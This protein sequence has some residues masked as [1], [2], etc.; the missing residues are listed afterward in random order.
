M[1]PTGPEISGTGI[2]PEDVLLVGFGLFLIVDLLVHSRMRILG[3]RFFVALAGVWLCSTLATVLGVLFGSAVLLSLNP[4]ESGLLTILKEAELLV[5]FLIVVRYV[6]SR[7]M[8]RALVGTLCL[9]GTLFAV[10]VILEPVLF[11]RGE[12]IPRQQFHLMGDTFAFVASLSAGRLFF[13]SSSRRSQ[14]LY[15]G[16]LGIASV[17]VL[18]SGSAGAMVGAMVGMAMLLFVSLTNS[19]V[20]V[21]RWMFALGGAVGTAAIA[22][23]LILVPD[24]RAIATD[25]FADL[26]GVLT[27]N[28]GVSTQAR[29]RHWAERVPKVIIN[30][31][32]LGFGQ[33]AIPP[34]G[35]D[36][37]Y[38]QRLYYTGILGL[39][40]YLYLL[41]TALRTAFAAADRDQTG[42]VGGFA[43]VVGVMIGSGLANGVFHSTK[44]SAFF[45]MCSALIFVLVYHDSFHDYSE[46]ISNGL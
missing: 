21:P 17:G 10:L 19:L 4:I 1:I 45:V 33:L 22:L 7:K 28:L 13:G 46:T 18:L 37:E 30:R 23:L 9:G 11:E 26:Y 32:I 12:V 16:S 43:G 42:F 24:F 2:R 34:G 39:S 20:R 14:L 25:Q 29:F 44:T 3:G 8:A 15:I 35:L 27:G 5:L 38:F 36:N 41:L 6:N 31:P 40:A